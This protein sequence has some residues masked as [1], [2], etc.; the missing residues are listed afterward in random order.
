MHEVS[1]A[2]HGDII[3]FTLRASAFL[4]HMV[5]NIVGSLIYVGTGRNEPDWMREVL[6]ARSRDA[7]APTFMPDGLYF[8]KIEY[9]PK[10]KL[11]QEDSTPLPWL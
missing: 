9:D 11:P 7:A 10:W 5:R 6:E 3:V 4:H 1:I 8:A 2:R